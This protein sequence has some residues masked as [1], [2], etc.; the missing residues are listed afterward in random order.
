MSFID[1]TI[2]WTKGEIFEG[3]LVAIAGVTVI[4]LGIA[5]WKL[6]HTAGAKAMFLPMM[7]C[8]ALFLGAGG[9]MAYSNSQQIESFKQQYQDNPTTFVASEKARV[10]AFQSLYSMTMIMALVCFMLAVALHWLSLNPHLRAIG[11]VLAMIG[12]AGL[13]IDFFSKER[14]DH[15]Y[16]VIQVEIK[17]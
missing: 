7:L 17:Q 8:G 15:Y 9:Y 10:E 4:L 11:I 2:L 6:G 14:A 12:V 16:A 3:T 1:H 5:F 13:T